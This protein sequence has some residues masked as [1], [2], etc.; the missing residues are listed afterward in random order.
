M[1]TGLMEHLASVLIDANQTIDV[2]TAEANAVE[3]IVNLQILNTGAVA[4]S[5]SLYRRLD[6]G[7]PT[8]INMLDKLISLNADDPP[9]M[10]D[11]IVLN[12]GERLIVSSVVGGLSVQVDGSVKKK[13][14]A[15]AGYVS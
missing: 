6:A 10:A 15:I 12:P 14:S 1:A 13:K 7:A 2:Y 5:A 4:T 9:Y 8:E 3:T 11:G